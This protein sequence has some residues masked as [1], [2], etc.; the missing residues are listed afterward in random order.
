MHPAIPDKLFFKIGEVSDITSLRPSV[1]RFWEQEFARLS[2][3]KSRSGQR[4]YSKE[5]IEMI[6][7]LKK[8]LYVEKLTI[9]GARN[10]VAGE[11]KMK[12]ASD[13]E[14]QQSVEVLSQ[15][16]NDIAA[17]LKI[18]RNMLQD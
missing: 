3:K 9:E 5:D 13:K 2:P 16:I 14:S 18:I 12:T 17:E 11:M 4:L 10:R 15:L 1:L 7:L 8:L 6:C